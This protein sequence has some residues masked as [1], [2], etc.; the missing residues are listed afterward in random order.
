MTDA[1]IGTIIHIHEQLTPVVA[2]RGSIYGITMILRGYITTVGTN[3][4]NGLVVGTMTIF[5][6]IDGGSSCFSQ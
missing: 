2:K 5:Q 3:L 4:T 1:L 6:F